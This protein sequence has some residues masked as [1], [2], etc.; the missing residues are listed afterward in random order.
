MEAP[1]IGTCDCGRSQAGIAQGLA[2]GALGTFTF[3]QPLAA[4]VCAVYVSGVG[5]HARWGEAVVHA[6]TNCIFS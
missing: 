3:R 4:V 5:W 1:S 2:I 6:C